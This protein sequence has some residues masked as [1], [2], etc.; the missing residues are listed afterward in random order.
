MQALEG[1]RAVAGDSTML[2]AQLD[3]GAQDVARTFGPEFESALRTM[4]VGSWQGPV[5]SGFGLHLVRLE[6]REDG[7][8]AHLADVRETVERDVLHAKAQA[9]N[10]AY[11]ESLRSKYVVRVEEEPPPAPGG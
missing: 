2:P 7:R 1:G 8:V 10:D 6:K 3:G 5:E 11:Y 4:P 9:A